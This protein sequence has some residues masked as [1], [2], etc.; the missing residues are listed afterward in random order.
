MDKIA[1]IMDKTPLWGLMEPLLFSLLSG[2][3]Y[4]NAEAH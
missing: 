4:R 2:G 3:P 1:K